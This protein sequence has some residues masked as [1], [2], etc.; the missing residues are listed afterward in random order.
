MNRYSYKDIPLFWIKLVLKINGIS[1]EISWVEIP[2]I[3]KTVLSMEFI[4]HWKGSFQKT[5]ISM[6][7]KKMVRWKVHENQWKFN[8]FL[9]KTGNSMKFQWKFNGKNPVIFC[10]GTSSIRS[11]IRYTKRSFCSYLTERIKEFDFII[12]LTSFVNI[13]PTT[14]PT[15]L[16]SQWMIAFWE[17]NHHFVQ[18]CLLY[19]IQ[20]MKPKIILF[21]SMKVMAT[22]ARIEKIFS[23]RGLT[24]YLRYKCIKI[25][26]FFFQ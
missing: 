3:K 18:A 14:L 19:I 15:K 8:G 7:G 10:K 6:V 1:L 20:V 5:V 13:G 4:Y 2:V 16:L 12:R 22:Q 11:H 26:Q 17:C 21:S 24:Q 25:E 23:R 9:M